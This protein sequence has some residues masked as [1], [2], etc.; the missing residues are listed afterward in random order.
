MKKNIKKIKILQPRIRLLFLAIIGILLFNVVNAQTFVAKPATCISADKTAENGIMTSILDGEGK[1]GNAADGQGPGY[2]YWLRKDNP[3]TFYINMNSSSKI[4]AMKFYYPWGNDEDAKNITIRFYNGASLLGTENLVLPNNYPNKYIIPLSQTYLNV[5]KVQFVVVDDWLGSTVSPN[6][7]T[8]LEEI[9]FG[10]LVCNA[11]TTTPPVKDIANICPS[12][13]VNLNNAHTGTIPSGTS[14][15]WYTNNTHTGTALSGT[16]VTQVTNNGTYYAFYYDS[17]NKCYSPSSNAVI[18]AIN[19]TDSDGDGILDMCDLDNDNDGIKDIDENCSG[20]LAQNTSG[21]WK[22]K[23]ASNLTATL[24]GASAQTAYNSDFFDAQT[25]YYVNQNGGE[26]RFTK[27]GNISFTYSFSTPVPAKEI[28][29]FINDLDPSRGSGSA[30][31][32]FTVNGVQQ[33][34]GNF[35]STNYGAV[36]YLNFDSMSGRITPTGTAESQQIIIKGIGNLLVSS[37]SITSTGINT[38]NDQLQYSLFANNPCDTDGDG[39]LNIYDLDSDGDGCP[40]AIEGGGS[41][42]SSQLTTASGTLNTQS[43]NQNFGTVVDAYGIP[44]IVGAS[45]QTIGES[46]DTSKNDCIDSDGDGYPDWQDLDDDNDGILDTVECTQTFI[47]RPATFVSADKPADDG[48]MNQILDGEGY[49]GNI[50]D[51]RGPFPYFYWAQS[52]NPVTFIMNMNVPSRI[53]RI[54]FY[55]PWGIDEMVKNIIVKLYNGASLLGTENIILPNSVYTSEILE[56][57]KTYN[58]VTKVEMITVDDY[59][60]SSSTPKRTSLTEVVFGDLTDCKDTDGDGIPNYLDLDSDNDGCPD[61]I[62]GGG[63]FTSSQLTTASGT[64]SSQSPNQNFGVAVDTNGIPTTVGVA[65]QTI[66]ESQDNSKNDCI[67]SDSDGYPDWQDLDD[68]NDGILDTVECPTFNIFADYASATITGAATANA[69][70]SNIIFNSVTGTLTRVNTGVTVEL[71]I[72]KATRNLSNA[73]IYTP[74]GSTTQAALSER[75]ANFNNTTNYT[76][77]TLTLNKPVESITL[78]IDNFD[79]LRTRFIGSHKEQLISG[80]A[81]LKYDVATRQLYDIAPTTVS[82]P[83]RDGYGS[84]KITSTDGSPIT[85]IVFQKFDDPNATAINDAFYYTFSLIPICDT[86]GDGI[87]DYL[88][89]DSDNDGCPDAIEGGASF[90]NSNLVNSSMPGGNSGATSG[91]YNKPI[92]QNLGNT[93]G[94]T[95]TTMGVP[96]IAGTGQTTGDSQNSSINN[97][98]NFPCYK[99]A[100]TTGTTLDTNH[101]ITALGRAGTDNS[102]WPMVRKGAWTVLEAKTKGFVVNRLTDAQ[103]SAIPAAQLVEGMMVYNI[104]QDCLQINVDGTATG[105]KCFNNQACPD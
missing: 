42:T 16:Q 8:S 1:T 35:I 14:L 23:T 70:V 22:G 104:S 43:Q 54:K 74:A 75:L 88:D 96:T 92:I 90:T 38:V 72:T 53:S 87:P 27:F 101:G 73:T 93:V 82:Q 100:Q 81:E 11:G 28:A 47:A 9:V 61:A 102:N 84:V 80:G 97:Q 60:M 5:T 55:S 10:D 30:V 50:S 25:H 20:F 4:S 52:N 71:G 78:H 37:I 41:F 85:Q 29:F 89:L 12:T 67:D 36:N 103:I 39:I 59:N 13:S 19:N 62:E 68:D 57:S 48:N 24:T 65:G 94:N 32:N 34:N 7:R 66:G 69:T 49:T 51:E 31:I 64:L 46:Q 63:N 44:T 6:P 98:C 17:V 56:L 15:V 105:W 79:N 86:D 91:T 99:P 95:T 21:V 26:P 18:V 76:T 40:D 2:F 3:V 77:Y 33:P 45:G 83:T 58:N